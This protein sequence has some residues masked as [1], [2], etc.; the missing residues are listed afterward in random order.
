[1]ND[2]SLQE[3]A[4]FRGCWKKAKEPISEANKLEI[5]PFKLVEEDLR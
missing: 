4:N 5:D 1:M 2:K 3:I